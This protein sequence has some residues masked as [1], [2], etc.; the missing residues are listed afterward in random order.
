[1]ACGVLGVLS[2][3]SWQDFGLKFPIA[4]NSLRTKGRTPLGSFITAQAS[5]ERAII[6][7]HHLGDADSV[8]PSAV[9]HPVPIPAFKVWH[10]LSRPE[11]MGDTF[12]DCGLCKRAVLNSGWG[13]AASAVLE[14]NTVNT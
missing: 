14:M 12:I 8:Y 2:A 11:Q 10:F 9:C 3:I 4:G 7:I 1:M 6:N 13:W 5:V